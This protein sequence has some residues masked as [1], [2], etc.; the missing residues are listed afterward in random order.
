VQ[1]A[2]TDGQE[3]EMKFTRIALLAI[4]ATLLA[5]PIF[6]TN[7]YFTHGQGSASK[8]MGG[9]GV[10]LPQDSIDAATNPAAI[11][12]VPK[13][14]YGAIALFNPNRSYTVTGTPSGYPGTF[15]LQQGKVTSQSKYFGMP[16]IAMNFHPTEPSALAITL[17]SHGGMNTDYRTNTFYG[18]SHTGVDL[19]QAFLSASYARKIGTKQSI[20]I[21]AIGA[22]QRFEATGLQAFSG[23]SN[24]PTCLTNNAHQ[25]SYGLGLRVGYLGYLLPTLS[26]GA[27]YSPKTSMT[28]FDKYCGLFADN[29]KFDIPANYSAGFSWNAA[30][31]WTI[32]G[33]VQRINYSKVDSIGNHLLPNLVTTPLGTANGAGFGWDDVTVYKAGVQ[34]K[35]SNIWALRAGYS[36]ANQPIPSSEVL[37]NILAPGVVEK[38]ITFGMSRLAPHSNGR[39]NLAVMYALENS[40]T[41]A[42]PMEAPGQQQIKLTMDEWEAELSYSMNF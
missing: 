21:S 36:Q 9:A 26:F 38:H 18:A 37:F 4:V 23:F 30:P 32:A 1:D 11:A 22:Y 6:A 14:Y 13:Q 19:A 17:I 29:G 40:V 41:G 20:G 15:G 16:A 10:A 34:W 8:A 5:L 28:E 7:G 31:H 24:E 12:F 42:N 33:D 39:V 27:T 25:N 35:P 2:R 3:E